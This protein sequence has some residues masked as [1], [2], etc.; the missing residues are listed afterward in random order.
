MVGFKNIVIPLFSENNFELPFSKVVE[1]VNGGETVIHLIILSYKYDEKNSLQIGLERAKQLKYANEILSDKIKI[2]ANAFYD[3]NDNTNLKKYIVDNKIDLLIL[4]KK[5]SNNIFSLHNW[6]RNHSININ[7]MQ[8]KILF[9]TKSCIKHTIKTILIPVNKSNCTKANLD[10]FIS[11]AAQYKAQI[12][13]VA[14]F[15]R[16]KKNNNVLDRFYQTYKLML[17]YGLDVHYQ[18]IPFAFGKQYILRYAYKHKID[19]LI[20]DQERKTFFSEFF[21]KPMQ[22]FINPFSN[23]PLH[24]LLTQ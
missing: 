12:H 5:K 7:N 9:I 20:M 24:L 4:L 14:M 13:L 18:V 2:I 17:L 10:F 11:V 23:Y 1:L 22:D 6:F 19:L 16:D 8:C 15:E 21:D 3:D